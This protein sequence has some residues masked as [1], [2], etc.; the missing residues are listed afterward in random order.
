MIIIDLG[1]HL[2]HSFLVALSFALSFALSLPFGPHGPSDVPSL[3]QS[4]GPPP[5]AAA[6]DHICSAYCTFDR[7]PR[8]RHSP[9]TLS[10]SAYPRLSLPLTLTIS[11]F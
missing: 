5:Q 4:R 7:L 6:L 3:V 2:Y 11:S 9:L 8:G 1:S 10:L